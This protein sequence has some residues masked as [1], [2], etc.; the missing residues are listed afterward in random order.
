[1]TTSA[2]K[3]IETAIVKRYIT[4]ENNDDLYFVRGNIIDRNGEVLVQSVG[5]KRCINPAYSEALSNILDGYNSETALDKIY[6]EILRTPNPTPISVDKDTYVGRSVQ[7]SL[8]GKLSDTIY[9]YMKENGIIGGV[10]AISEGKVLAAVSYPG[11][12]ANLDEDI[13]EIQRTNLCFVHENHGGLFKDIK[14]CVSE[15]EKCDPLYTAM[16]TDAVFNGGYVKKAGFIERALDTETGGVISSAAELKVISTIPPRYI[17]EIKQEMKDEAAE[18]GLK[19]IYGTTYVKT[20]QAL[21]DG[22][23]KIRYFAGTVDA[24]QGSTVSVV[25]QNLLPENITEDSQHFRYMLNQLNG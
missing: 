19:S 10:T 11:Y 24:G 4:P 25:F 3:P 14:G 12:D 20:A 9:K 5:S 15:D 18:L 8:D 16:L 1:M 6:E 2:M 22:G 21:T 17:E 13:S 7:I 23:N